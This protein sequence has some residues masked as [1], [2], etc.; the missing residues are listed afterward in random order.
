V[1][2]LRSTHNEAA[3]RLVVFAVACSYVLAVLSTADDASLVFDLEITIVPFVNAKLQAWTFLAL[4]PIFIIVVYQYFQASLVDSLRQN[5]SEPFAAH[6]DTQS[7]SISRDLLLNLFRR[8]TRLI[9]QASRLASIFVIWLLAPLSVGICWFRSLTI[10]AAILSYASVAAL[11]F[12]SLTTHHVFVA[13]RCSTRRKRFW[14]L[15][16]LT[17]VLLCMMLV[18]IAFSRNIPSVCSESSK[19]DLNHTFFDRQTEGLESACRERAG[20]IPLLYALRVWSALGI[21]D[22]ADLRFAVLSSKD[23]KPPTRPPVLSKLN[24]TNA[25]ALGLSAYSAHLPT[26]S[27]DGA[28]FRAASLVDAHLRYS[29]L[30][31]TDFRESTLTR[32]SLIRS[33][34]QFVDFDNSILDGAWFRGASIRNGSFRSASLKGAHFYCTT[35][36]NSD[37]S[38]IVVSPDS[39]FELTRLLGGGSIVPGQGLSAKQKSGICL[40]KAAYDRNGEGFTLCPSNDEWERLCKQDAG[41]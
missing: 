31:M 6:I 30:L 35:L 23:A 32:V 24:L 4:A 2:T 10:H 34:M 29:S 3:R 40:D 20:F 36:T 41:A 37:L 1:N 11:C 39:E 5:S 15:T 14:A 38:S 16:V 7:N 33:K 25:D 27:L 26:S 17:A 18:T 19:H 12:L 22:G 13:P 28:R 8:N 21:T 9:D